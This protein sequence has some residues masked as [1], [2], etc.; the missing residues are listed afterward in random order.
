MNEENVK[1]IITLQRINNQLLSII[2]S[3]KGNNDIKLKQIL[4]QLYKPYEKVEP[5]YRNSHFF[6]NQYQLIS[7]LYVFVVLPK[8]SFFDSIPSGIKTDSLKD[9]WGINQLLPA[10]ELKYFLRRI[11]NAVSHGRIEFTKNIDFTFTDMDQ[12]KTDIFKVKLS[13]KELMDFTRALAYWCITKDIEL[14]QL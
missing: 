3:A 1:S 13:G 11:R 4:D 10:Y 2:D 5:N 7:S 8:E 6:F 14:K 12:N 9:A